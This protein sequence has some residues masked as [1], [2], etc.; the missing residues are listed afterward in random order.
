MKTYTYAL[1][2]AAAATGM[3]LGQTAYTTPVGYVALG[4]TTAGQPAVKANTDVA[5]GIPLN[6][7][8]EYAGAISGTTATTITLGGTPAFTANQWA[9]GAATPY[10]VSIKSGTE[11]GFIGLITANTADT[12]TVT[13]VTGGSLVAPN[14]AAGDKVQIYKAWT[15]SSFL[16]VGSVPNGTRLLAYFGTTAGVNL[17]PNATYQYSTS[18]TNWT[19]G[20]TVSNNVILYPGESYVLRSPSAAAITSLSVAGEVPVANSRVYI[21][22]LNPTLGQDTRIAYIG[23]G[24]EIIGNSGLVAA[25]GLVTGDRLLAFNNSS[26]GLNKAPNETLQWN[27]TNWVNGPTTVTTTY[28]LKAGRGYVFRRAAT[29]PVGSLDWKDTPTYVPTL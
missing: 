6:R 24:E 2:A 11:G 4:D 16:P 1:L 29:A 5:I 18:T 14:V 13:A 21:D 20:P 28:T 15:L 19:N 10:L 7:P 25:L 27:G 12:L 8:T 17:A 23:A 3:A 22:K 26:A 9:P